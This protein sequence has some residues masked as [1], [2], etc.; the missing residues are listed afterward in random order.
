M[1]ESLTTIILVVATI[2]SAQ[3]IPVMP[4]GNRNTLLW[5]V[6]GNG[7]EQ[8]SYFLGTMHILCP[9]D[10]YLSPALLSV[11][12]RVK[13]IYFEIDLDNMALMIGAMASMGMKNDTVLSDLLSKEDYQLVEAYFSDKMPLPFALLKRMKPML[14]SGMMSEQMLP[15]KAG[16]GTEMLLSEEAQKRKIPTLGLETPAYQFG[17]FDKIPYQVQADELLKA[18][19][20]T[21][22]EGSDAIGK[23]LAAF[24]QQDLEALESLTT[25]EEGGMAG[26][27]DLLIYDRNRNWVNRFSELAPQK[28]GL[29]A[30]G[31]GHLP[32]ENGVIR[33]LEMK[34]YTLRPLVNQKPGTQP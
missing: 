13:E 32:G 1:K 12:D 15:C 11:L 19:K 16:S 14:L 24:Q 31:A 6:S 21:A 3:N 26:N 10:A 17:L 7:L 23:M 18:I 2:A 22:N 27:L 30:V 29:Y 20:D 33:L 25:S 34:G 8:P 9:E 28:S 5:E 4:E